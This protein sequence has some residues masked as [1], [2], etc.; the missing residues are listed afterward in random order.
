MG[1]GRRRGHVGPLSGVVRPVRVV[2]ERPDGQVRA[3]QRVARGRVAAGAGGVGARRTGDHGRPGIGRGAFQ[4]GR[5]GRRGAVGEAG[6]VGIR[7]AERR[8]SG[9]APELLRIDAALLEGGVDVGLQQPVGRQAGPLGGEG[10]LEGMEVAVATSVARRLGCTR[11]LA[12]V[13]L[14]SRAS[15]LHIRPVVYQADTDL[16]Q[17]MR[18]IS[19][20]IRALSASY[21]RIRTFLIYH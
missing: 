19:G 2:A 15:S 11:S 21:N 6:A 9:V 16:I 4:R 13:M 3:G 1:V 20:C 14:G 12:H 10:G 18:C 7:E 17:C 8:Q 5:G